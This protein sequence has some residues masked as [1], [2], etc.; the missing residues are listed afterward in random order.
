MNSH[1]LRATRYASGTALVMIA[2]IVFLLAHGVGSTRVLPSRSDQLM[3]LWAWLLLIHL[4]MLSA[5]LLCFASLGSLL[6]T[7][8]FRLAY[9]VWIA[10]TLFAIVVPVF[11]EPCEERGATIVCYPDGGNTTYF[12]VLDNG[13]LVRQSK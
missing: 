10:L 6:R 2:G 11:V 5:G 1:L 12:R 3:E 7:R 4:A 13:V 8:W 9:S